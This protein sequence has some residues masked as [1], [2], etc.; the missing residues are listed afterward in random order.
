MV[1]VNR[2]ASVAD[3]D[4]VADSRSLLAKSHIGGRLADGAGL[5][6]IQSAHYF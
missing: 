6:Y 4:I 5:P 3:R 1:E 2:V